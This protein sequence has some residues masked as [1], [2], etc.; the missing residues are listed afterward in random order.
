MRSLTLGN[1]KSVKKL[2]EERFDRGVPFLEAGPLIELYQILTDMETEVEDQYRREI[3]SI[4]GKVTK[5]C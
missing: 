2:I 5:K 4:E 1:I 3:L